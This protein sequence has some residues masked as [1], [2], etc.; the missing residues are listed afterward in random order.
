MPT[1]SNISLD[2]L[3]TCHKDLQ[4]VFNEV[5]KYFDCVIL[6]GTRTPQE[7]FELFK[8]GRTLKNNVWTI[9]DKGK[10]VTFKDGTKLKSKH[11][12]GPSLAV[13]VVPYPV[14]W[15]DTDRMN[16]FAGFVIGIARVFKQR[17][18]IDKNITW[19]ADLN[20][21]KLKKEEKFVDR[22]HFEIK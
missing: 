5:I 20:D 19:G 8:Q 16:Y 18:I 13:D 2:R 6:Y 22:P 21:N 15:K 4:T 12:Y 10:V 11:N 17:G 1:F 9:T 7:Q 3:G 14:D